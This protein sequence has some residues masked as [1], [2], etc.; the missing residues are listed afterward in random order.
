[1]NDREFAIAEAAVCSHRQGAP[2]TN[3]QT[4]IA[5]HLARVMG[6]AEFDSDLFERAYAKGYRAAL[7]ASAAECRR[8]ATA[9]DNGGNEYT[10]YPDYIKI[11]E[12]ILTLRVPGAYGS[13]SAD[14]PITQAELNAKDARIRELEGALQGLLNIVND[15]YGVDG[16]H[17]NG[18][19]AHWSSFD[20]VAIAEAAIAKERQS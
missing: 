7:G 20:E 19:V 11:A 2:V 16:Y 6:E 4:S 17:L 5:M 18:D 3:K 12:M 15:S 13:D 10:R 14:V 8:L 9:L 1:M